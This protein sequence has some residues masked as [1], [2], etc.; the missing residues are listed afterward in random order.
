MTAPCSEVLPLLTT[1][2]PG[3]ALALPTMPWLRRRERQD[4]IVNLLGLLYGI[5]IIGSAG[6]IG[7]A[8]VRRPLP[9]Q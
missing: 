9:C 4:R 2:S 3:N 8:R 1:A 7:K 5:G 6:S